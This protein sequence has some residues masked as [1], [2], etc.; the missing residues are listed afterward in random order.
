MN[1]II[2]AAFWTSVML[3][4]HGPLSDEFVISEKS[5]QTSFHL[6]NVQFQKNI[7]GS[8]V[9]ISHSFQK[10]YGPLQP[11]LYVSCTDKKAK[12]AGAGFINNMNLNEDWHLALSFVPG[13]YH[14]G[15]DEDLGGWL[16]FRSGIELGYSISSEWRVSLAYDHRSSGDLW[17][18]NPGLETLQIKIGRLLRAY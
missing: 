9:G 4:P 15:N 12:W 8:E 16:M 13:V 6:S 5:S 1:G 17:A 10:S 2:A 18:Y 14:A 7:T 3:S 11:I